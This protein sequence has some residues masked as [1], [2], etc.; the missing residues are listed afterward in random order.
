MTGHRQAWVITLIC[1]VFGP[2]NFDDFTVDEND[3]F[4]P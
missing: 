4:Y 1:D 3:V 2:L